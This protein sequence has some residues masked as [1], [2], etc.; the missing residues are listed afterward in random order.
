MDKSSPS[1]ST[2][3][4]QI[5]LLQLIRNTPIIP[6]GVRDD[7]QMIL[8]RFVRVGTGVIHVPDPTDPLSFVF[9]IVFCYH[10]GLLSD[11]NLRQRFTF[12]QCRYRTPARITDGTTWVPGY[13]LVLGF[14]DQN[15]L[16]P[17]A[18]SNSRSRN[19]SWLQCRR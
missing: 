2:S 14:V 16:K 8:L 15:R 3:Y 10:D 6:V 19:R 9:A 7:L 5:K 17:I 12:Y 4:A 13:P 11:A 1:Q 18:V